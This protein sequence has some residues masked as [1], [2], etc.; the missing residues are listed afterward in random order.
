MMEAVAS[1]THGLQGHCSREEGE[2]WLGAI[3]A[4]GRRRCQGLKEVRACQLYLCAMC[5]CVCCACVGK[6][7]K[8]TGWG[9]PIAFPSLAL[10]WLC[11]TR[12]KMTLVFQEA[13]M[14][15]ELP[16]SPTSV[17]DKGRRLGKLKPWPR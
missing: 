12:G 8:W 7:R 16:P 2:G 10:T 14:V 17:G 11:T 3:R 6:S 9:N 1:G 15:G 13:A 4:G 5:A